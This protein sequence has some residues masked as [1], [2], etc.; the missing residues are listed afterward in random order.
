MI[1]SIHCCGCE[2][3]FVLLVGFTSVGNTCDLI[4]QLSATLLCHT[5]YELICTNLYKLIFNEYKVNEKKI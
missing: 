1:S 4:S 3:L 5:L 2:D